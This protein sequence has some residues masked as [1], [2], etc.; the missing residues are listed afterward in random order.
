[1][2]RGI[3]SAVVLALLP[4]SSGLAAAQPAN[5]PRRHFVSVSLDNFV[6]Q[7]LHFEKWP[8]QELVGRD[9]AAAQQESYDYRS[10]DGLT[11]VDVNE[12]R[13]RGRGYG[14]TVYPFGLSSGPT[15]GV[16]FSREDL[17]VI[18]MAIAGPAR[19]SSYAMTDGYAVDI[20]AAFVMADRSPGWGLGS[21]AFVGA[22]TGKVRSTLSDGKR[23]FAE[24]GG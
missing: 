4:V 12:F 11:T 9:V 22:G 13:K 18:R 5:K 3:L 24:G 16:R 14:V 19:L 23:Y 7:P 10:R 20:G 21:H 6:T 17:P 15:L 8:V 2:R 1:M